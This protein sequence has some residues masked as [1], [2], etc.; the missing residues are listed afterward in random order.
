MFSLKATRSF[1][2]LFFAAAISLVTCV[3]LCAAFLFSVKDKARM[4]GS[5]A[6][7]VAL[8]SNGLTKTLST[9]AVVPFAIG[10]KRLSAPAF[11]P[12]V[13]NPS[14]NNLP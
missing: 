6:T 11:T 7:N 2:T 10:L 1:G 3:F 5:L 8:L 4:L 12:A 9:A 14:L 13:N